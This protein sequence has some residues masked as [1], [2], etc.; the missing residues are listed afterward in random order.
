MHLKLGQVSAIV[1][2]SPELAE[3]VFKTHEASAFSGRPILLAMEIMS[4]NCSGIVTSPCNDYWREMRKICVLELLSA[5]RVQSFASLREE[6]T[7]NLV[8]SIKSSSSQPQGQ[9]LVINLSEMIFSMVNSI[10]ARAAFGKKY[11]HQQEFISVLQEINRFRPGFDVPDLFPSLKFLRHVTRTKSALEKLHGKMDK[12]LEEII[13]DHQ[14]AA[15]ASGEHHLQEDL[16]HVLIQL[17]DSGEL[18]FE[19]TTNHV[20]AVTLV[21]ISY[22]DHFDTVNLISTNKYSKNH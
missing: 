4:Y 21:C 11:K 7:W 1:I 8:Q 22:F 10:T 2:S 3:Q 12:I 5:K 15:G 18:Q 19:L 6:E 13:N 14:Q 17:Q 20:K 16:V 9:P